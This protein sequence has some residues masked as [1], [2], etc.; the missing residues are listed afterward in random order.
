MNTFA[1]NKHGLTDNQAQKI[2]PLVLGGYLTD[3]LG[4]DVKN[5]AIGAASLAGAGALADAV[6]KCT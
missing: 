5:I 6:Y 3:W 1:L 4:D 2:S